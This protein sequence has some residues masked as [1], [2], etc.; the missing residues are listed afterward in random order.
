MT[1]LQNSNLRIYC[2]Q[3]ESRNQNECEKKLSK[4]ALTLASFDQINLYDKVLLF[5]ESDQKQF[6]GYIA[7]GY[8]QETQVNCFD[9]VKDNSDD[10]LSKTDVTFLRFDKGSLLFEETIKY[11]KL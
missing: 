6:V 9:L 3:I 4:L 2:L 7:T 8:G 10:S 5:D 1:T 11:Q